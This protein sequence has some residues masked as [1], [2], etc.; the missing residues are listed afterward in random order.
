MR[1]KK[2]GIV[3]GIVCLALVVS[4]LP[5]SGAYAAPEVIN[6]KAANFFPTPALQSKYLEEFCAEVEKR[7]NG[8]VKIQYFAGGSLLKAPRIYEGVVTGIA[9]IGYSHIEYTPGRFPVTG[10]CELPLSYPS[11][12]VSSQVANDFYS[13]YA[14]KEWDKVKVL[15]MNTSNPSLIISKVPVR[16]L[17][18]L[19]GLTIRAPGIVGYTVKALGGTPAPT[20]MMEVYDAMAKGVIDGVNTPFETLKTFRFAEVVGYTTASW[21]TGNVYYFYMVMNKKSY[22]KLPPDIKEIFDQLSGEYKERY[23]LMWNAI[24]F[25]GKEFAQQK[26]VEIIE[27]PEYEAARWVKAAAPV[28]EDYVK[29]MVGKGHSEAEVRGW[30]KFIRERME[31]WTA[32]QLQLSIKSPTG[33]PEMRP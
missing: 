9:D 27:L 5:F 25:Y 19:K 4:V 31:Y 14:P 15:W 1:R 20:P 33:P 22:E 13:T 26:G 12:W 17:E 2:L 28:I 6:L 16:K 18:D 10:A 3:V 24:D 21:H 7:T 11:A 29:D 30:L 8:R 23:A 32:K